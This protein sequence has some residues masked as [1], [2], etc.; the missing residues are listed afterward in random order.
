MS[1]DEMNKTGRRGLGM[2]LGGLPGG[3]GA[4]AAGASAA[5]AAAE[6]TLPGQGAGRRRNTLGKGLGALLGEA[7]DD[8]AQLDAA[9]PVKNTVAIDLLSP[10]PYQPR[11]YFDPAAMADLAQSIREK[12]I[13]QPLVVRRDPTKPGHFQIIAGERRWR[14]A[15]QAGL[16]DVP[17]IVR[18]YTDVQAAEVSLI[19][20]VQRQDLNPMEEAEGYAR[21]NK[22][23]G[24]TQEQIA[25]MVGKSRPHIT[26]TMRLLQ[27][28]PAAQEDLRAGAFTAGHARAL[29]AAF[30]DPVFFEKFMARP[31]EST[32][33]RD[34]ERTMQE[35]RAEQ[36]LPPKEKK[37]QGVKL[38]D[39][40]IMQLEKTVSEALG[41]KVAIMGK[42]Q[43]GTLMLKYQ[44]L[45]QLDDLLKKLCG[46]T[47]RT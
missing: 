32:T 42:G 38:R 19:E 21:L 29:L 9:R 25:K 7:A 23:F 46:V 3:A 37:H 33:V 5:P 30:K 34:F 12:G 40:N 44:T 45:E 15:Q 17:V 1:T 6:T 22:E 13:I 43:A 16:H 41:L 11:K 18:E 20:N 31:G 27:L 4:Q 39:P 28:T 26:N 35:I 10:G 8:Y 14:A 24:Y 36:G 47:M 2:G